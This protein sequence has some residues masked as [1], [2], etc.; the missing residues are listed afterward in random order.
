L[1]KHHTLR[2]HQWQVFLGLLGR[3]TLADSARWRVGWVWTEPTK[4]L[5][6]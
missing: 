2:A 6:Q 3:E 1:V 4:R 5:P